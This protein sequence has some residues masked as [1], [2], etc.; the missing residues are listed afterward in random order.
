[1]KFKELNERVI[2]W[3]DQKGILEKATPLRQLDKTFEELMELKESLVAQNN[4]LEYYVNSKGE[5]VKTSDQI[6]DDI[7]DNLVTVLI[8]CKMQNLNPLKCLEI[9]LDVIEKRGG[10]MKN[11]QFVKNE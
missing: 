7:G 5:T 6:K 11:G 4:N 10:E 9:V 2:K 1:M 8:Q 3:A